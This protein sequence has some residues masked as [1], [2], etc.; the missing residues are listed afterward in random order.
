MMMMMTTSNTNSPAQEKGVMVTSTLA[1]VTAK[2]SANDRLH[3]VVKQLSKPVFSTMQP[4]S[5]FQTWEQE[6]Q[7]LVVIGTNKQPTNHKAKFQDNELISQLQS[8]VELAAVGLKQLACTQQ[9][10]EET[11]K[12]FRK[13]QKAFQANNTPL[14]QRH[15]NSWLQVIDLLGQQSSTLYASV[16]T[17]AHPEVVASYFEPYY[18]PNWL[19]ENVLPKTKE[20]LSTYE[21]FWLTQQQETEK[22]QKNA[23]HYNNQ[24]QI[25]LENWLAAKTAPK[26]N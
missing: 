9:F 22:R 14:Y 6:T 4:L 7:M 20:A 21:Q 5:S 15:W 8:Q 11:L 1:E 10:E 16:L 2:N 25:K 19:A 23:Q 24:V 12:L 13:M 18:L 3:T 17:P 26:S